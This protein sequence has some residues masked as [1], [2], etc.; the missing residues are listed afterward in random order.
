MTLTQAQR[1]E[2]RYVTLVVPCPL[3]W[4]SEPIDLF[5]Q[6]TAPVVPQREP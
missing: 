4:F 5:A 2:R 6:P 1:D 3:P